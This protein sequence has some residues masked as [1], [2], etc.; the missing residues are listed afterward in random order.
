[1]SVA[2]QIEREKAEARKGQDRHGQPIITDLDRIEGR[3]RFR[4][5][6]EA[7]FGPRKSFKP[8]VYVLHEGRSVHVDDLPADRVAGERLKTLPPSEAM[9][10]ARSQVAEFNRTLQEEGI[11]HRD[12]HHLPDGRLFLRNRQAQF[13]VMAQRGLVNYDEVRGGRSR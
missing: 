11:E 6:H 4:R 7:I 2:A 5:N 3:E 8:G 9:G 12:A 10:C 1:M 13:A